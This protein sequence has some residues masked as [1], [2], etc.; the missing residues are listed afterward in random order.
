MM[1]SLKLADLVCREIKISGSGDA[2]EPAF[3]DFYLG[4]R[5]ED[6][7]FLASALSSQPDASR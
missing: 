4:C 2:S 5:K 1:P 7:Q 6:C 3:G